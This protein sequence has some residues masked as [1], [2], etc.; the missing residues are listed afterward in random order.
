MGLEGNEPLLIK[1]LP[2]QVVDSDP[3]GL[4]QYEA[5]LW[6]EWVKPRTISFQFNV[7]A[8][9]KPVLDNKEEEDGKS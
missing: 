4:L 6:R 3:D 8:A 1:L 5:E 7:F 2:G 9:P